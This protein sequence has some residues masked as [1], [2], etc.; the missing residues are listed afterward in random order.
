ME[1]VWWLQWALSA[2]GWL[3]LQGSQELEGRKRVANCMRHSHCVIH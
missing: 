1:A 2:L 3:W